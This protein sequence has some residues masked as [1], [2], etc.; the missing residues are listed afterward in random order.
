MQEIQ[1]IHQT[2]WYL[3]RKCPFLNFQVNLSLIYLVGAGEG[4][5]RND[6]SSLISSWEQMNAGGGRGEMELQ[7][8]TGGKEKRRQSQEFRVLCGKFDGKEGGGIE[9]DVT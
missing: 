6:I 2:W 9:T 5:V 7:V 3:I 8:P 4:T 1:E